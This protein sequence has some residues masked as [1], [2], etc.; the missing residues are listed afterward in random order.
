M[1]PFSPKFLRIFLVVSLGALAPA[2]A[3]FDF[4]MPDGEEP[5]QNEPV[6]AFLVADATAVAPGT[7]FT[8][9]LKL[10]QQPHWHTYYVNPGVVGTPPTVDWELPKGF[11]AS[12]LEFPVPRIGVFAGEN[13]YGYES[14]AW[15]LTTITP[16]KELPETIHIKASASWLACKEQCLPGSA[17][18]ELTLASAPSAKPNEELAKAFEEA[19]SRIPLKSSPWKITAIDAGDTFFIE[20]KPGEGCVKKLDGVHFFSADRQDDAQKPQKL[21]A[22]PEGGWRL[23]VARA[24]ED[25]LGDKIEKLPHISG[26]L[27]AESGWLAGK[28]SPGLLLDQ[29]PFTQKSGAN[30]ANGTETTGGDWVPKKTMPLAL[31]FLLMFLGGLIL[32][33]MPCVFPVIGLKIMGFVQ[34]AGQDRK[35]VILH[36]V[37]FALGVLISFWILSGLLLI[38][39]HTAGADSISWGGQLQDPWM[40]FILML[41]MLL[42]AMNMFGIFEIGASATSVGGKLQ[43]AHGAMGSFFSGVLATVVSTP[44]AAPFLGVGIGAALGLPA[45]SFL[46]A[47][48]FMALGLALPYLVLSAFPALTEKLPRPGPW[49]ES[50]KEAMSFLLFGTAG[51]LLWVYVTLTDVTFML[52]I[53]AGLTCVAIAAWIY[54]RWNLPSRK[55]GTR[56]IA[57]AFVALFGIAGVRMMLPPPEYRKSAQT[58]GES[59]DD[60]PHLVWEK[61][62]P[63]KVEALLA[64]GTPVYVDF[65]ASWCMTCQVNKK[66]AYTDKVVA[67]MKQRGIVALK[68]DNTKR[69]PEIDRAIRGLGRGAVPVNVLYVPGKKPIVAPE[70]L[71]PSYLFNLFSKEIPEKQSD[72]GR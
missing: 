56:L 62:S 20:L 16:P 40:V 63:E 18:L 38:L 64:E 3:Q 7:P 25:A 33:L 22:M 1:I 36:G 67:L 8:V 52:N 55:L 15:F 26:I 58:G 37:V 59:T 66:V 65:T 24:T 54:G 46:V 17:D 10:V 69:D 34:L 11:K 41:V 72:P 68:A 49:M 61:W 21:T 30:G 47:F 14:E 45:F 27:S 60:K 19:R 35:K 28:P 2:F 6:Q 42:L 39:R 44:C 71:S 9:A 32:N 43:S 13:F 29:V 51:Y 48:T 57:L 23:E 12:E 53:I 70:L 50:F 4:G 31:I 5:A